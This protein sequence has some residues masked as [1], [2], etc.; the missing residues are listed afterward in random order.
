MGDL[1]GDPS[2]RPAVRRGGHPSHR[3]RQ[4]ERQVADPERADRRHPNRR[5]AVALGV[6]RRPEED[7]SRPAVGPGSKR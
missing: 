1:V 3:L 5:P 4:G 6:E 7:P 2:H